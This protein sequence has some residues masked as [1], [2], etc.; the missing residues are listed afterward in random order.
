MSK[1]IVLRT[2]YTKNT[3]AGVMLLNDKWFGYTLEDRVRPKGH[4]KYGR[5]AISSGVYKVEIT[6]SYRYGR[7]MPLLYDVPDFSGV[8]I[9][10]GN[11][12]KDTLGCILVA[13]YRISRERIWKSLEKT[14]TKKLKANGEN[15]TIEIIDGNP[16]Y[17]YGDG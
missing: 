4:K 12:H 14:L 5:T 1:I 3:T 6:R 11:S 7:D 17:Y 16:G 2:I 15:H 9:H 8:R 10:G 13:R